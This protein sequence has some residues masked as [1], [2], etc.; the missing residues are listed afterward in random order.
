MFYSP[1]TRIEVKKKKQQTMEI[2]MF[3]AEDGKV[4]IKDCEGVET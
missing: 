1:C 2:C 4:D 3:A